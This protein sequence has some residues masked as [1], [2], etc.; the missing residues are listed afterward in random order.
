MLPAALA[1]SLLAKLD[2]RSAQFLA[3]LDWTDP[4][5]TKRYRAGQFQT[6]AWHTAAVVGSLEDVRELMEDEARRRGEAG[7]ARLVEFKEPHTQ[8]TA[9]MFAVK[10]E[11][12][13]VVEFLLQRNASVDAQDNLGFT[14]LILA[15]SGNRCARA[16]ARERTHNRALV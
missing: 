6:S 7:L 13:N 15:A 9:L 10:N 11:R 1:L 16:R 4:K 2:A 12:A 3:Q 14:P 8:G 5:S